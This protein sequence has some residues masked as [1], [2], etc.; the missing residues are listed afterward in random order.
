[1]DQYFC[2]YLQFANLFAFKTATNACVFMDLV[3][4]GVLVFCNFQNS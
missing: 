3:E 2:T 4:V 1:M